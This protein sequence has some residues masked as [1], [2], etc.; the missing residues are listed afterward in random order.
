MDYHHCKCPDMQIIVCWPRL[1]HQTAST[2]AG[3]TKQL[4]KV[5][6]GLNEIEFNMKKATK[7]I[8]DITRGL[9]TDK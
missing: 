2:L 7:V 9:A 4:E 5:V 8:R 1:M 6:D 3:Q